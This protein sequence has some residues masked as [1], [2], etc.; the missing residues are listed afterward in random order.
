MSRT[1]LRLVH[2]R[3]FAAQTDDLAAALVFSATGV[4]V[5]LVAVAFGLTGITV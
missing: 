4:F 1:T 3:P 2:D 5:H